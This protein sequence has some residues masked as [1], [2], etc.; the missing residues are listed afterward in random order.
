[1]SLL[2]F[3]LIMLHHHGVNCVC[4]LWDKCV[5]GLGYCLVTFSR[6]I[7]MAVTWACVVCVRE[8]R[9]ET[10]S[11]LV[12]QCWA[13]RL[14]LPTNATVSVLSILNAFLTFITCKNGPW[15]VLLLLVWDCRETWARR[16]GGLL[17]H[18]VTMV[19]LVDNAHIERAGHYNSN[20]NILT[21][22]QMNIRISDK[23]WQ[24]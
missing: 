17:I 22:V 3:G 23:R 8:G 13:Y 15:K 24:P 16:E 19:S 2:R 4:A 18:D 10:E 20:M 6:K 1:M 7:F 9:D 5:V 11:K 14:L 21:H 12:W